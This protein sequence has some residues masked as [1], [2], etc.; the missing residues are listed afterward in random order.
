MP[1]SQ[2]VEFCVQYKGYFYMAF[3]FHT[4]YFTSFIFKIFYF[5]FY[6]LK[7]GHFYINYGYTYKIVDVNECE[8]ILFSFIQKYKNTQIC[9][10]IQVE[11]CNVRIIEC[12]DTLN[13]DSSTWPWAPRPI[14][15]S[16]YA[17]LFFI[18]TFWRERE[19]PSIQDK[20]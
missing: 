11:H 15:P 2:H 10:Y 18:L 4:R 8:R 16:I 9:K 12:S 19:R 14:W 13:H 5:H 3:D 20:L 1:E 7:C 17:F 6:M